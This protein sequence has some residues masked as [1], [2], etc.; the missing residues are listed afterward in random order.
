M[1]KFPKL[2]RGTQSWIGCRPSIS[3]KGRLIFSVHYCPEL[4]NGFLWTPSFKSGRLVL[5]NTCGAEE[6]VK[7]PNTHSD[8]RLIHVLKAGAGKTVHAYVLT[9][10]CVDGYYTYTSNR[11]LVV[12][13]LEVEAQNNNIG[14]ACIYLN[15]KETEIQSLPNLLGA[16]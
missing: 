5:G 2:R 9:H 6:C 10:Y 12:N 14:L 7:I 16:L 3:S 13:Y 4:V 1:F 8:I 11:S 15:Y